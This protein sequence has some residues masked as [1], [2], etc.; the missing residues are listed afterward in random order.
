[1][2]ICVISDTHIPERAKE[3]PKALLE[4]FKDADMIIHAG[5]FVELSVLAEL[6]SACSN[7]R[8]VHGNMDSYEVKRALPEKD[9]IKAGS[10]KIGLM[11]GRGTPDKLVDIMDDVFKNDNVN[12]IIFGH[13]HSGFNEKKGDILFF[14]P[15]SPTDKIFSPY[16][17]Y[18]IIEIDAKIEA[19]IIKI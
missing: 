10:Y 13:S 18:G 17:S 16:N 4:V 2:K 14:N 8:A 5:D 3:L 12:V 9:I 6:K 15:G 11:H 7:V 19:K 1:M